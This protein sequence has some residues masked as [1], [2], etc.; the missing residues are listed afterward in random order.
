MNAQDKSIQRTLEQ[1][2]AKK[3]WEC[4]NSLP[5]EDTKKKYGQLARSAAVDIQTNG[6][7]QTLSFWRSKGKEE[8]NSYHNILFKHTSE[9]VISQLHLVNEHNLLEWIIKKSTTDQYRQATTEA[10]S[11]LVWLKRFAESELS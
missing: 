10:I 5:D 4:V 2:R 3:A 8:Q 1:E 6:L 9:W 11:F 7:G